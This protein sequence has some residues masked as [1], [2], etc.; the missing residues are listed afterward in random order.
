MSLSYIFSWITLFLKY[1]Y[2][3]CSYKKR[4]YN[5]VPF[6]SLWMTKN[7]QVKY[8][9]LFLITVMQPNLHV[10]FL[11]SPSTAF[12]L[13]MWCEQFQ[14]TVISNFYVW[15]H[16]WAGEVNCSTATNPRVIRQA[17]WSYQFILLAEAQQLQSPNRTCWNRRT[18]E[19]RRHTP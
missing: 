8:V 16:L 5:N 10:P 2:Y 15:F 12:Y 9:M 7:R 4:R 18:R 13:V 3:S 11:V 1:R 14:P 17:K 6:K 19:G